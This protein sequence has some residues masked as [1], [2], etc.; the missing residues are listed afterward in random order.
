MESAIKGTFR[1]LPFTRSIH[2]KHTA[3]HEELKEELIAQVEEGWK[4]RTRCLR[5][6]IY[7]SARE[8]AL[9]QQ[10]AATDQQREKLRKIRHRTAKKEYQIYLRAK[11][12]HRKTLPK[13]MFII[14]GDDNSTCWWE[15]LARLLLGDSSDEVDIEDNDEDDSDEEGGFVGADNEE[16][17]DTD[18]GE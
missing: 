6:E 7:R 10:I 12:T 16:M 8:V 2:S 9:S 3:W 13:H 1:S 17:G 11:N 14:L 15:F 5:S 18:Q 4:E